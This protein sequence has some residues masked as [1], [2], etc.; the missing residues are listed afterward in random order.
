M[1][2]FRNHALLD[3]FDNNIFECQL[4]AVFL[5]HLRS[6]IFKPVI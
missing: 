4:L 1:S 6:V 3:I 2:F 5:I